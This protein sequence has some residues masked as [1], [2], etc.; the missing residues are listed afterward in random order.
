MNGPDIFHVRFLCAVYVER[1]KHFFV[2][3]NSED[4]KMKIKMGFYP[5]PL[6]NIINLDY[7]T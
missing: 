3:S 4:G 5:F 2:S 1:E 6:D 7:I